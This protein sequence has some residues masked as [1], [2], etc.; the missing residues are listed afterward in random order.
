MRSEYITEEELME[1]L[2]K[3]GLEAVSQVKKAFVEG[4]GKITIIA[5]NKAHPS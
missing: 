4:D 1:H 3:Q 2:R 5:S